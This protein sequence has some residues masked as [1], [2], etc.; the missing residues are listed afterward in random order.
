MDG[1]RDREGQGGMGDGG[2]GGRIWMQTK[3]MDEVMDIDKIWDG[4]N[5]WG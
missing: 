4:G 1:M 3:D 5:G 2:E